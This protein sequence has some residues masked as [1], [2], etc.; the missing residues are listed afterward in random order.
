MKGIYNRI[1]SDFLLP[2]R[3]DEYDNL[4]KKALQKGYFFKTLTDY[5]HQLDQ[6]NLDQKVFLHRHDIDTDIKTAER[7]FRVEEAN[8]IKTSYYF[9]LSTIDVP[10]MKAINAAGH[11]VGYHFEEIAQYCKD[12]NVH[13]WEKVTDRMPDIQKRFIDNFLNL[14]QQLGFK[15]RSVVSH[16]D[17]VNRKL[18]H[19]NYELLTPAIREQ[20]GIEMEGYDEKLIASFNYVQSDATF[21]K[22]YRK[23]EHPLQAIEKGY[24]VIHLLTHPRHWHRAPWENLKDNCMRLVEGFRYRK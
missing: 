11:E 10:L 13:G 19:Q 6:P 3:L 15:I 1:Y 9:R 24:S 20:L 4:C 5:Y 2:S 17:F 16:G 12:Y 14:E 7:F 18:G 21:P 8:G 23:P 22:F